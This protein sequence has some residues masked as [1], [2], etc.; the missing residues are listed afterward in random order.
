LYERRYSS[1]DENGL[2]KLGSFVKEGDCLIGKVRKNLTTNQ[3][4]NASSFVEV[5]QE[6]V[7]DR[8]LVSTNPEGAR[9][10]KV[11]IRQIRKPVLGDKF[12]SRFAQKGT[13]G[14]ILPDEDMPFTA[15]GVRPDLIINPH[16]LPSRMTIGKMI[17][18]VTSKVAA[19]TGERVNATAF[20]NFNT[21]EF[22]RNLT[23]Y[24]YSS[25]GKERMYSGFD[26]KPL[27]ARIFTGP[28]YYQALRHQV[29][30]KVQMR[31]RGFVSQLTHQPVG[32]RKRG[33]GQRVGE[34]ERDAIISHGASA[35]LQERLCLV[36]DAFETVYCSTCGTMAIA[37]HLDDKYVCRSCDS[38]KN[39]FGKICIPYSFKLM[40]QLLAGANYK[41][42]FKTEKVNK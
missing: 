16:A 37:N 35:F 12:A 15:S 28:C 2:P 27:E 1:I 30:D 31:A 11:K 5:K 9:V 20:R 14:M 17:E 19:F 42:A 7:V 10:V 38:D 24:G 8:V 33:G 36:S 23:Q 13:I 26:G 29:A 6:G 25:S 4:E 39:E 34:M 18:I 21:E 3:I 40:S 22:M 32:G 41:I